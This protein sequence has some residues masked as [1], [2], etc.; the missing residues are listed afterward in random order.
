M[1]YDKH[2]STPEIDAKCYKAGMV[3]IAVDDGWEWNA[4]ERSDSYIIAELPDVDKDHPSIRE[5]IE[6][7]EEEVDWDKL[8]KILP[9]G[10]RGP[11]P[12]K[13]KKRRKQI[14]KVKKL[15]KADRDFLKDKTN[16][17][18][19]RLLKLKSLFKDV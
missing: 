11:K 13:M 9:V 5:L 15:E 16:S 7:D 1:N 18:V 14:L 12:T 6:Q 19:A 2:G 10:L 17:V 3:V 4:N 8:K